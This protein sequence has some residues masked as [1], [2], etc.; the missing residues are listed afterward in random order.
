PI[1]WTLEAKTAF[2]KIKDLLTTALVLGLPDFAQQFTIEVDAPGS[3]IGVV[4]MQR[5]HPI[6]F[7]SRM[8]N[9]QQQSMS[10]YEKV[11]LAVQGK[12]NVVADALSRMEGAECQT[13]IVHI[14]DSDMLKRTKRTWVGDLQKVIQAK[15]QLFK[16]VRLWFI[17]RGLTRMPEPSFNNA[18]SAK[19]DRLSKVAQFIQ[20]AHPYTATI[21]AQAFMANV[22][23][24]HGFPDSITSNRDPVFLSKFWQDLM[25][26]QRVQLQLSTSYHPQT[27]GQ[28]E[29]VNRC[30][31]TDLRCMCEDK[32]Q[33]WSNWLHLAEWWCNTTFHTTTQTTSYEVVYGQPPPSHL[34]YLPWES[35][36]Q[37]VDRSLAKM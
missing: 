7:I 1:Q 2:Q 33:Q 34:P 25:A 32:P 11:L 31:E 35:K 27:N 4:L 24:L 19:V 3:G 29:I 37:L 10:T 6:S 12:E 23:K 15:M 17:R 13:L 8:L 18:L 5:N 16:E 28:I 22:F 36:V 9:Q 26:F 14:V 20:L 30:L 21:V